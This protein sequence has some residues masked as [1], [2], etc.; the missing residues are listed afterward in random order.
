M[1]KMILLTAIVFGF[2]VSSIN[3]R[4]TY[5]RDIDV[6]Y[7]FSSLDPYGEWIEIGYDD[8]IWRPYKAD[9]NWRPYTDG[10]WEWTRNGWYWTS[11]EPFG[12]ATYHYGRWYNDDFYGWVWMPDDVWAPAWVE[13]RYNDNY[14]GW[15][16]LP[17]YARYNKRN[18]IH[19]SINWHSG[20][21]YWNF[22]NYNH[23]TSH[24]MH[25]YYV[26]KHYT[27]YVYNRT[28]RRTNYYTEH[29]RIVNG[30]VSRKYVEN[31]IGRKLTTRKIS[32]T[33]N[34]NDYNS[35]DL[36]LRKGIVDFRPSEKSVRNTKFDKTKVTK[37]RVLKSLKSDKVAINKRS[38]EKTSD[39]NIIEKKVIRNN[40]GNIRK[41]VPNSK[42]VE[43][44]TKV[45]NKIELTAKKSIEK[46]NR[47]NISYKTIA[48]KNNVSKLENKSSMKRVEKKVET[49]KISKR[50]VTKNI[51]NI[52]KSSKAS[53]SK[54][55]ESS[56]GKSRAKPNN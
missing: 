19:F 21:T 39:I 8:Y 40:N 17:P 51:E 36:K 11:Y 43:A 28:K 12:W 38:V 42:R 27:K 47:N 14:I 55:R 52:S 49:K 46:N 13:W 53:F 41:S 24:N 54:E 33:D 29:D 23:F 3:A 1:K 15:A 22:V 31:K 6:N 30:G 5:Y 20:Y 32:R 4:S 45:T 25:Y 16:P 37:G 44:D 56:L 50:T 9:Y 26:N 10:R 7:F 18:G 35:K 2:I 34:Y 48:K